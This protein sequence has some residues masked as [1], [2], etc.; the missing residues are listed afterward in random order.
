METWEPQPD[1]T[2]NIDEYLYHIEASQQKH[3]IGAASFDRERRL[4]Y[5]F[6][7]LADGAKPLIHVW[8]VEG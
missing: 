1:A 6:E 7:P 3:H 2:L 4:L 5:V 8:R